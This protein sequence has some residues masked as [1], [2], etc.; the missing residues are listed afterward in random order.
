MPD[1]EAL[2]AEGHSEGDADPER[3]PDHDGDGRL[4]SRTERRPGS[5]Q[6]P[7]WVRKGAKHWQK[8][9]KFLFLFRLFFCVFFWSRYGIAAQLVFAQ[10][11]LLLSSFVPFDVCR[12][13]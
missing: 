8:D 12:D 13:F 7:S 11:F 4:G 5:V 2:A 9:V 10:V 6:L 3:G 1:A